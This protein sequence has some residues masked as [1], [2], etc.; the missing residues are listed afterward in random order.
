[1]AKPTVYTAEIH[2]TFIDA[3]LTGSTIKNAAGV[4]EIGQQTWW[5]WQ[6][7]V[8]Q[9]K[10]THDG[11]IALVKEALLIQQ[12]RILANNAIITLAAPKDWR[13]A[14]FMLERAD[15][16]E[17]HRYKVET[18]R[19]NAQRA[20]YEAMIAKARAEGTHVDHVAGVASIVVLP[21]LEPDTAAA[22]NHLATEPGAPK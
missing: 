9:G 4:S 17:L 19:H 5:D 12:K 8:K 16:Q 13:A 11:I 14:A 2:K 18:A 3:L 20:K 10:C 15:S 22:T 7:S 6:R 1:M 21:P